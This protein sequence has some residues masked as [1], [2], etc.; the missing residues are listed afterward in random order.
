MKILT[1][2]CTNC[3]LCIEHCPMQAIVPPLPGD[4]G[5]L[6]AI[7][8]DRC[9][10]CVGH[11]AWPRCVAL[12]PASAIRRDLNPREGFQTL[13]AK[14]FTLTGVDPFERVPP[15]ALEPVLETG[16]GDA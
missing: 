15:R 8:L 16:E 11:F 6:P 7:R 5:A 10:E 14:W 4:R 3:G 2:V 9:T 1:S 12:C 13:V